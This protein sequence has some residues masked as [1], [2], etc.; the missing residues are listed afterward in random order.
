MLSPSFSYKTSNVNEL[1]TNS[2]DEL[3]SKSL[4]T[5]RKEIDTLLHE[6]QSC[7]NQLQ[8]LK[9]DGSATT[10]SITISQEHER[11]EKLLRDE[12]HRKQNLL[13]EHEQEW[14]KSKLHSEKNLTQIN[15]TDSYNQWLHKM[16]TK[17]KENGYDDSKLN[18]STI[19]NI[20]STPLKNKTTDTT[21]KLRQLEIDLAVKNEKLQKLENDIT[22]AEG[23][24]SY[25]LREL[26]R[27]HHKEL[28]DQQKIS[29]D[30]QSQIQEAR[31]SYEFIKT[32]FEQQ[33]K[34]LQHEKQK[35]SSL[36]AHAKHTEEELESFK[37]LLD[38]KE[39]LIIIAHHQSEEER[40]KISSIKG[41]SFKLR[42]K[43]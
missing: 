7:L 5:K 25:L 14:S 6:V 39:K 27:Q 17:A 11:K 26:N 18:S 23:K 36:E 12:L 28:E 4:D 2:W 40:K 41:K 13:Q 32:Q 37:L 20:L 31:S 1:K 19:G 38:Q 30:L 21:E 43:I 34:L 8:K 15:E 29:Y 33:G 22:T 3:L 24:N 16:E 42:K 35:Y 9:E 10:K